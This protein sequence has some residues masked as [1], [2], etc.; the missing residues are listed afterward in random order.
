MDPLEQVKLLN[1]QLTSA[2]S[3]AN[4]FLQN[5]LVRKPDD[6]TGLRFSYFLFCFRNA[7]YE[8]LLDINKWNKI[9]SFSI[10]ITDD[11][12]FKNEKSIK[13]RLELILELNNEMYK[14]LKLDKKSVK[15]LGNAER[16]KIIWYDIIDRYK[17]KIDNTITIE[18]KY[19]CDYSAVKESINFYKSIVILQRWIHRMLYTPKTGIAYKNALKSFTDRVNKFN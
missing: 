1:N 13:K 9:T 4:S 10:Y 17:V 11:I 6:C 7:L 19:I 15:Y 5:E 2:E 3:K 12:I 18:I 8:T 16:L 14:M